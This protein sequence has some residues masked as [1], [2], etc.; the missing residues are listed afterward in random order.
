MKHGS[1]KCPTCGRRSM[2]PA[3]RT[4]IT[5]V[6]SRQIKVAGVSLEE[7]T[8]CGERLYDL[9]ALRKLAAARAKPR[10]PRAA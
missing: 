9:A 7:C 8:A 2:Q 1:A 3:V 10:R 4:V 5:Y 6:G